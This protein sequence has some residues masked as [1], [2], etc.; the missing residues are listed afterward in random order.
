MAT[1]RTPLFWV[2]L[3]VLVVVLGLGLLYAY[4]AQTPAVPT[5]PLTQAVQEIQQ[6]RVLEVVI[7]ENRATLGLSDGSR[8]ST[9]LPD[10]STALPLEQAVVA[11]NQS[12][13]SRPVTLRSER[14]T[15]FPAVVVGPLLGLLPLVVLVALVVAIAALLARGARSDR[16]ERLARA[17]DLRDR[18]VL[19]E[20]E[21]QREKRTILR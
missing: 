10:P 12:N 20:E 13:P 1:R 17:A 7:E 16:Y 21:F 4:R 5:V 11:Y 14:S 15:P 8:Q 18:G 3:L 2:A 19:T 9:T 6:G